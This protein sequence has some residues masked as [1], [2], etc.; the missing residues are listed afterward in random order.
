MHYGRGWR[1]IVTYPVFLFKKFCIFEH[2]TVI[3]GMSLKDMQK[4]CIQ[5]TRGSDFADDLTQHC[6][7]E[8][9]EYRLS[10]RDQGREI[11]SPLNAFYKIAYNQWNNKTSSFNKLHRP[12]REIPVENVY[13][14]LVYDS[15]EHEDKSIILD[16]ILTRRYKQRLH[17][18]YIRIY[19]LFLKYGCKTT[20]AKQLG[21]NRRRVERA[22]KFVIQQ[23]REHGNDIDN[24]DRD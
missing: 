21:C 4:K 17:R 3:D 15:F 22:E 12:Y 5:V 13:H 23:L 18:D 11:K 24:I 14:P 7:V 9:C 10:E 16:T 8:Y 1:S 20:T 6:I 19:S 2:M